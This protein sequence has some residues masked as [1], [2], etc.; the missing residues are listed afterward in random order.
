[1]PWASKE[2]LLGATEVGANDAG[3]TLFSSQATELLRA[4]WKPDQYVQDVTSGNS[5]VGWVIRA[6]LVGLFN[7]FQ[8]ANASFLPRFCLI[9]GCKRY[10]F[11]E[12][13]LRA[14]WSRSVISRRGRPS[15][16]TECS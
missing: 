16:S 4:W 6:L 15:T 10:P 2:A 8:Q 5:R 14:G 11:I 7:R 1:V 9:R 12:E 13:A 3:E